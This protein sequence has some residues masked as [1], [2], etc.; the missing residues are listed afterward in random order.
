MCK[1]PEAA[2][3][4]VCLNNREEAPVAGEEEARGRVE[5]MRAER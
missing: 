5:D 4:L 1:G 2:V 3:S